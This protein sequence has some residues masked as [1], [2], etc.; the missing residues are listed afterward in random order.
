MKTLKILAGLLAYATVLLQCGKTKNTEAA[1][2]IE[3]VRG[4]F[5]NVDQ[6]DWKSL[7]SFLSPAVTFDYTS[8]GGGLPSVETPTSI[9]AKWQAF[10]PGFYSTHHQLGNFRVKADNLEGS[11][12]FSGLALHYLPQPDRKNIWV[13][14]GTYEFSAVKSS[15]GLWQINGMKF[16]VKHQAG[17]SALVKQ[18]RENAARKKI[19]E[20]AGVNPALVKT[21]DAFFAAL[22]E[23]NISKFIEL[24]QKDGKQIMPLSPEGFPKELRGTIAIRKQYAGL[25][26]NFH[27]MK[28]SRMYFAT[29]DADRIIVQYGGEIALKSGGEYNNNYVAVMQIRDGKVAEFTEY[30]DPDI[31][32]AA[33]GAKLGPNFSV[34]TPLRKVS[35][36]SRGKNLFGHLHLPPDFSEK[37]KYAGVIVTG[38]WTTV[39]EQ[40]PDLYARKLSRNG[41]AVLT[42]DFR[43]YGE[44]EG[45][46]RDFEE[47]H[48]KA[49][50]IQSAVSYL[51]SLPFI[52]PDIGGL[53]VCA[54]AGYMA[55]A[56]AQGVTLQRVVFVAP[57]LHNQQLAAQVYGGEK[58]ILD[59]LK[60]GDEAKKEFLKSGKTEYVVAAS[61]TDSS[62]AMFGPFDYYLN[63]KRGKIPEWG[64]RFALMA[65]REWLTYNPIAY[66]ERITTPILIIH[67]KEAAIPEGA[68]LFYN[69]LRGKKEFHWLS[70]ANQFDFYDNESVTNQSVALAETW[71]RRRQ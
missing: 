28:F 6:R 63:P 67:S 9:I 70:K 13:V 31:L 36:K 61:D 55:E 14:T 24:W 49:E 8:L 68:V 7:E 51:K 20:K 43:N 2:I 40:M 29:A 46:P 37:Q 58:G 54:S 66:A 52:G 3:T 39:K 71:L 12:G 11:A 48:R 15:E 69:S 19:P 47:P 30:F 5:K 32:S 45:K 64:N 22:E 56:L 59:R 53:A 25:P 57:W 33:F 34:E 17:N 23:L 26:D 4:I 27:S 21:A 41:Y 18:A 60:K 35:F 50:D 38:S 16:I 65:W 1:A 44:S 10:L 42:F 62:A